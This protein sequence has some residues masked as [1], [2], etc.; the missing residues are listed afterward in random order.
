MTFLGIA[1]LLVCLALALSGIRT[2]KEVDFVLLIGVLL[3]FASVLF[4]S[5]TGDSDPDGYGIR[6][7][8][9]AA[10][11]IE[12]LFENF[13]TGAYLYSWLISFP[14]RILGEDM[15]VVRSINALMS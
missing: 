2:R 6:A 14:Y 4:Y 7:S 9:F 15:D 8:M 1:S 3:R 13:Q 10:M 5:C 11:S 12:E